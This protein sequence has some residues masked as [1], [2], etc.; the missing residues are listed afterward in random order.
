MSQAIP[1]RETLW[2]P[3]DPN[4]YKINY[5]AAY[6]QRSGKA[7]IGVIIRDARGTCISALA[8]TTTSATPLMAEALGLREAMVLANKLFLSSVIFESNSLSLIETCRGKLVRSEI[9]NIINDVMKLKSQFQHCEFTWTARRG[10]GVAHC[11]ASLADQGEL[12]GNWFSNPPERLRR[13][14]TFDTQNLGSAP[15]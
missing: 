2:R 5:D 1:K 4:Y 12:C 14:I 13:A 8:K 9:K 11:I 10:N 6:N 7:A 3:P 15:M